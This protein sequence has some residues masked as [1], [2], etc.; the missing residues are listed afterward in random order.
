MKKILLV[1][2]MLYASLAQAQTNSLMD[3]VPQFLLQTSKE[4]MARIFQSP[5]FFRFSSTL[6]EGVVI[7]YENTSRT[8]MGSMDE[9]LDQITKMK[10][11]LI[12]ANNEKPDVEYFDW[13]EYRERIET[14]P[15]GLVAVFRNN[16]LGEIW[17]DIK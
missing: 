8:K 14:Y 2:V 4:E 13:A 12:V 6:P 16:E 15:C 9:I 17:I 10:S 3:K 1:A 11:K 5:S 7:A